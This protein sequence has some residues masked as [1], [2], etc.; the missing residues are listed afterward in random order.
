MYQIQQQC[1]EDVKIQK[2]FP[3][4]V[5]TLYDLDVLAEDTILLWF[6]KGASSKG[7]YACTAFHFSA[8]NRG[9]TSDEL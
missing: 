4:I 1:Y 7:R 8:M 5:R 3:D 2:A 6:N 9:H